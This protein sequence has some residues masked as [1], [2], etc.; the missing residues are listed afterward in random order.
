MKRPAA[1][2]TVVPEAND[3]HEDGEEEAMEDDA[4][5]EEGANSASSAGAHEQASKRLRRSSPL[6]QQPATSQEPDPPAQK[7]TPKAAGKAKARANAKSIAQHPGPDVDR[8]W[9]PQLQGDIHDCLAECQTHGFLHTC[10][11]HDQRV[12]E[13]ECDTLQFSMYWNRKAVGLKVRPNA[14]AKWMQVAYFARDSPC[15]F[16]NLLLAKIWVCFQVVLSSCT[17]HGSLCRI[18]PSV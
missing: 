5:L 12:C 8:S 17:L 13:N 14:A 7:Q 9:E 11:K 10:T 6:A 15:I 2:K 4:P 3:C 1:A 16:T 18:L